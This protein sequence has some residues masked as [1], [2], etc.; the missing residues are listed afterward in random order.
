M[1]LLYNNIQ[2]TNKNTMQGTEGQ[3]NTFTLDNAMPHP[4]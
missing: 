4:Q 2:Y 1:R 3:R